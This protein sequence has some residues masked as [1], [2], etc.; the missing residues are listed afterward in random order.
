MLIV[1]ANF[2]S[3]EWDKADSVDIAYMKYNAG[4][5]VFG[6]LEVAQGSSD[7]RERKRMEF[8]DWAIHYEIRLNEWDSNRSK[9]NKFYIA[10]HAFQDYVK[11]YIE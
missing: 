5:T 8:I 1:V 10:R 6:K 2:F 4:R 7:Y 3:R 9:T 11:G